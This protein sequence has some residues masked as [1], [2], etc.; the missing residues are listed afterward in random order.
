[1]IYSSFSVDNVKKCGAVND[2]GLYSV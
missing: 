1:L 2:G